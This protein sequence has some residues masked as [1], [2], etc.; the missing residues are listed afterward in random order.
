MWKHVL[1]LFVIAVLIGWFMPANDPVA[2]QA[3]PAP[4]VVKPQTTP[5]SAA[6]NDV[7]SSFDET[8]EMVLTRAAD[9][10]Y[11]ASGNADGTALRF[12]VDTGATVVALTQSDAELLGYYLH[13][14]ELTVVGRA[15]NG[16]VRGKSIVI[17]RLAIGDIS[18]D[19][20]PAVIIPDGLRV[21]LLGQSFLSRV[22]HVTISDNRMTL[23]N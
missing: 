9:G 11:Y 22:A 15:V 12:L 18:A 20:V 4:I 21:S 8:G 7:P 6:F 2:T 16:E 5:V 3:K 10:H 17:K 19:N 14:G 13:P 1:P 23:K